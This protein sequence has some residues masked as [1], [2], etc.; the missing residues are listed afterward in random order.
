MAMRVDED[1]VKSLNVVL[2]VRNVVV[3]MG[4]GTVLRQLTTVGSIHECTYGHTVG[5][6]LAR[7]DVDV[8]VV[9]TAENEA[10]RQLVAPETGTKVLVL[11]DETEAA[12]PEIVSGL[13][14]DGFQVQQELT[15]S[16]LD[17]VL[18]RIVGG[19]MSMPAQL[20]KQLFARASGVS[21]GDWPR[22]MSL[23]PREKQTLDLLAAGLSN[24]QLA[25]RLSISDHGAK[26]LVTSIMLKFGAP[27]RTAA[28]VAG[29]RA[30]I[31]APAE[32]GALDEV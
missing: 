21:G 31:I 19:E 12:R 24:K 15:A 7:G 13:F 5:E 6:M 4:L 17:E 1:M 26:R 29:I 18:V 2:F 28:V 23:T 25:R 10:I 9:T 20:G 32:R 16:K 30:G 8:V 22:P 14:A 11:L 27:N 3:R